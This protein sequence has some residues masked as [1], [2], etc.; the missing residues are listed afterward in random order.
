M[1]CY[2]SSICNSIKISASPKKVLQIAQCII[3]IHIAISVLHMDTSFTRPFQRNLLLLY[4]DAFPTSVAQ[5]YFLY[6]YFILVHAIRYVIG[7]LPLDVQRCLFY[8]YPIGKLP[9]RTLNRDADSTCHSQVS[10]LYAYTLRL[11][12]GMQTLRVLRRHSYFPCIFQE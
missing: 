12:L 9:L 10:S 2:I 5:G 1:N 4:M 8:A 3:H 6:T 7:M 11:L